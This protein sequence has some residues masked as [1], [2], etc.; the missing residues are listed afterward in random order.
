MVSNRSEL[1][2][3]RHLTVVV[4]VVAVSTNSNPNMSTLSFF[5]TETHTFASCHFK[6]LYFWKHVWFQ[7]ADFYLLRMLSR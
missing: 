1:G 3:V 6:R 7:V 5:E 4:V 2:V